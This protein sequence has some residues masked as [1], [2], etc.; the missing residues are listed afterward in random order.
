MIYQWSTVRIWCFSRLVYQ[1]ISFHCRSSSGK[2]TFSNCSLHDYMHYVSNFDTQCLGDLSN[3]HVL[4]P[5]QAVCGNG[6][7]EAGEECD[8]GNE[9]VS[10]ECHA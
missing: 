8:C 2:K 5:N 4:Q 7:M 3:V 6:I 9:T 1:R 10:S